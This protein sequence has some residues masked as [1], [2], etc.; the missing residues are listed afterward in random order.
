MVEPGTVMAQPAGSAKTANLIKLK[1][2][3]DGCPY[4]T[5][6][7]CEDGALRM[8]E[9]HQH[10]MHRVVLSTSESGPRLPKPS[11]P[12]L[13]TGVSEEDWK[14][15]QDRW[16]A[17]KRDLGLTGSRITAELL[18]C[19]EESLRRYLHRN[20]G[21]GLSDLAEEALLNEIRHLS[22]KETSR[23]LSRVQLGH[24]VQDDGE[25]VRHFAA[26]IKGIASICDYSVKCPKT[27]CNTEVSYADEVVRDQVIRGL[28]NSDI[29]RDLLSQPKSNDMDL[30]AVLAFVEA[31]ESGLRSH[32]LLTD[33]ACASGLHPK[34]TQFQRQ[35]R[36]GV[37][38]DSA[39]PC[40][41]CGKTGHG[42]RA[43]PAIRANR[44]PAWGKKC[45]ACGKIGHLKSVCRSSSREASDIGPRRQVSAAAC[46]ADG[47][48]E[49]MS[50]FAI[51]S[52]GRS[53]RRGLIVDHHL[54]HDAAGWV[55]RRT[56]AQP[57]VSL[58][59]AVS[60]RSY[61][62]LHLPLPKPNRRLKVA[63]E[64]RS[65]PD[66]GAQTTVSGPFLLSLLGLQPTDL[67][68]V[69]QTIS[70][71]ENKRM[72]ILGGLF[73]EVTGVDPKGLERRTRQLCYIA[74]DCP[75]SRSFPKSAGSLSAGDHAHRFSKR[76]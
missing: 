2:T 66:T 62:D 28:A 39:K 61:T 64:V 31:K 52:V 11:R 6:G 68:P 69:S 19:C 14:Y 8:L 30:E 24:L 76:W 7:L 16:T 56:P 72:N 13:T 5:P 51:G 20:L 73:I 45:D 22:V 10:N 26:R 65:C 18:E 41:F 46:G 9:M 32:G 59:V 67:L 38:S 33:V 35:K 15:F 37:D 63:S 25:S 49:F 57:W 42:S 60:E 54:W 44:C 58:S 43:K 1:C 34:M 4:T 50:M 12:E 21:G 36:Q 53:G 75:V 27:E 70:T 48:S 23:Q 3:K 47:H 74:Q 55:R 40:F 71:A 29:Q 17:Y